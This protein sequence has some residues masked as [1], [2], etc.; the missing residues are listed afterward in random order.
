MKC[1]TPTWISEHIADSVPEYQI[2]TMDSATKQSHHTGAETL[3]MAF[4]IRL[5][6]SNIAI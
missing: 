2:P 1:I 5:A 4:G 6:Q 3:Y